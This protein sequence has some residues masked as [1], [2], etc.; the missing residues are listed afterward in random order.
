M[1]LSEL[2]RRFIEHLCHAACRE[3]YMPAAVEMVKQLRNTE[4]LPDLVRP[5][6]PAATS[7]PRDVM[8]RA[9]S[10]DVTGGVHVVD[11]GP[12]R[13]DGGVLDDQ[14]WEC[15]STRVKVTLEDV[16]EYF[17]MQ[18][19]PR[20]ANWFMDVQ[21]PLSDEARAAFEVLAPAPSIASVESTPERPAPTDAGSSHATAGSKRGRHEDAGIDSSA[22]A[23]A[24][25]RG[26]KKPRMDARE[27]VAT[28]EASQARAVAAAASV[29]PIGSHARARALAQWATTR[30]RVLHMAAREMAAAGR[31]AELPSASPVATAV[32]AAVAAAGTA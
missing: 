1:D 32:A 3:Y 4:R 15:M 22:S 16:T 14:I 21:R 2:Y 6:P 20:G 5:S 28:V 24:A 26:N 8:Q 23:A 30:G 10:P 7:G 11:T 17:R 29:V 31:P 12:V 19:A 27:M 18:L 25:L 13:I 9:F